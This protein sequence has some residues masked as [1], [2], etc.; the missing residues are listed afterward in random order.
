MWVGCMGGRGGWAFHIRREKTMYLL[1]HCGVVSRLSR[2]GLFPKSRHGSQWPEIAWAPP[3]LPQEVPASPAGSCNV[4]RMGCS[5]L[6]GGAAGEAASGLLSGERPSPGSTSLITEQFAFQVDCI[7]IS[8]EFPFL[9]S[10]LKIH[11]GWS[12]TWAGSSKCLRLPRNPRRHFDILIVTAN[13][14]CE[15]INWHGWNPQFPRAM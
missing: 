6:A 5:C 1:P 12:L 3:W 15:G 9:W 7:S 11:Y 14:G 2:H 10:A 13:V 8:K 4:L